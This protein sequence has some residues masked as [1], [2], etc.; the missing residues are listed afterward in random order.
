MKSAFRIRIFP[1][2]RLADLKQELLQ[3]ATESKQAFEKVKLKCGQCKDG[4][5]KRTCAKCVSN[6]DLFK[7]LGGLKELV[8]SVPESKQAFEKVELNY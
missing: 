4:E 7:R 8:Q 3:S 1:K 2:G 6:Y 5:L